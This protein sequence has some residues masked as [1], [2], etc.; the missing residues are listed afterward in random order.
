VRHRVVR[1]GRRPCEV[2]REREVVLEYRLD[3]GLGVLID[4]ALRRE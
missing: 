3:V 4:E 2:E 1:V